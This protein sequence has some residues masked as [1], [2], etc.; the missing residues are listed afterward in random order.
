[1]SATV[2]D[3]VFERSH[4]GHGR[5]R[6]LKDGVW[7]WPQCLRVET[8][9][10]TVGNGHKRSRAKGFCIPRLLNISRWVSVWLWVI[11]TASQ[12]RRDN[13][14]RDLHPTVSYWRHL[15]RAVCAGK[16]DRLPAATIFPM[17]FVRSHLRAAII[18]PVGFVRS[19]LRA[20]IIWWSRAVTFAGV[21]NIKC[22]VAYLWHSV[23][24]Q[25]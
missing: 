23:L 19:H 21:S 18:Y 5:D 17:Q 13:S 8:Q 16:C 6:R 22:I 10:L 11:D 15:S 24:G 2:T 4:C 1:M 25:V 3:H 7:P 12:Y 20:A 14:Q 9:G